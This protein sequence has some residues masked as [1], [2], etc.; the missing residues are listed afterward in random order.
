MEYVL[1]VA[2]QTLKVEQYDNK[3]IC[4][5]IK[6]LKNSCH[7]EKEHLGF[8]QFSHHVVTCSLEQ[9]NSQTSS[10]DGVN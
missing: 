7:T 4:Y 5:Q 6:T 9:K 8:L 1:Q 10:L 2:P 3:H